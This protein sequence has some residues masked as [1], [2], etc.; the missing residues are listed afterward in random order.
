LSTLPGW[1]RNGHLIFTSQA[2]GAIGSL[3]RKSADGSGVAERL[4]N[5]RSVQRGSG[6][7]ADGSGILFDEYSDIMLLRFAD[8]QATA[9]G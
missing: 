9:A 7:L 2:A 8:S 6:L 4:T 5:G 1:S 3:F